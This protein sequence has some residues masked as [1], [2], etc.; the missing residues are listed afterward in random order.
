M[1]RRV[2]PRPSRALQDRDAGYTYD[3]SVGVGERVGQD[4]H[5]NATRGPNPHAPSARGS[6]KGCRRLRRVA[7]LGYSP[8]LSRGPHKWGSPAQR[9]KEPQLIILG[10]VLVVVGLVVKSLSVLV[11]IGIILLVVGAV[12][13]VLGSMGRAVGG[14]KHYY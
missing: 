3:V 9:G 11:T 7:R 5:L 2:R 14:R 13:F 6:N 4:E 8:P 12:L 1:R 10:I